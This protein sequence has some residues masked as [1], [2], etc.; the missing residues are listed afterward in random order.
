M[1][2]SSYG[3]GRASGVGT[4]D[5]MTVPAAVRSKV[6][7]DASEGLLD[8]FAAYHQFATDRFERRLTQETA[9]LRVEFRDGLAALRIETA[10][11][12]GELRTEMGVLRSD[13]MK[14]AFLLWVGQFAALV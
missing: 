4:M 6:G 5:T 7:Q 14:W 10:N 2:A 11:L 3:D 9:A 13:L 1:R 12:R 8:M